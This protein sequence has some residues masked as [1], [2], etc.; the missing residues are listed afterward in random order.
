MKKERIFTE[1]FDRTHVLVTQI[2]TKSGKWIDFEKS[3]SEGGYGPESFIARYR[4]ASRLIEASK[5]YGFNPEIRILNGMRKQVFSN[6]TDIINDLI[7]I[8]D[9]LD[10]NPCKIASVRI[11]DFEETDDLFMDIHEDIGWNI[12]VK[13]LREISDKNDGFKS[14][15]CV[16]PTADDGYLQWFKVKC[17]NGLQFSVALYR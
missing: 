10:I 15:H 7:N 13:H 6:A 16:E 5:N 8:S 12:F 9:V 17:Y 4:V 1:S 3:Y 11:K 2:K 14:V